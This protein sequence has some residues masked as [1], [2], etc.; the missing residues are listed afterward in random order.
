MKPFS[1]SIDAKELAS[2]IDHTLL[3][4]DATEDDIRRLCQEAREFS[5]FGVCVNSSF[6]PLAAELL[7]QTSTEIVSVIGFPLGA[8][9]TSS[10]VHEATHALENGA[11]EIDMVLHV[12]LLK[13]KQLSRVQTD[14]AAVAK[15]CERH[16]LKVIIETGLLSED[17]KRVAC[18]IAVAAGAHYVKTCTGFSSGSATTADILL[19]RN[20]VGADVGVKASGGIKTAAA[21][22][23]LIKAGADRLGTSSGPLLVQGL[24]AEAG[25]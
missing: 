22:L 21:A 6:V 3:K 25:Y 10:K 20:T 17:E 12:G 15:V 8:M 9:D 23:E 1:Q 2:Y 14:I 7:G 11:S 16:L 19:M 5:F 24:Q 13:S 4:P 18:E